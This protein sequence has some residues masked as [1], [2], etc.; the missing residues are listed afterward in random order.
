MPYRLCVLLCLALFALPGV[1]RAQPQEPPVDVR[2]SPLVLAVNKTAH[3]VVNIACLVRVSDKKG[4]EGEAEERLGT[5]VLVDT[6]KGLVL[7][8]AHVVQGATS[9]RVRL[10]SGRTLAAK[11]LGADP[12]FDIALLQLAVHDGLP[13]AAIFSRETPLLGETVVAI[14]NP[15]GF[16]HSVSM[17]LVSAMRRAVRSGERMLLTDLIQTDAAINP[18]NSGGPLVNMRGE[19][20]GITTAMNAYAQG[21]SFAIPAAKVLQVQ[22][23]ILQSRDMPVAWLGLA[24]ARGLDVG[25]ARKFGMTDT[26]GLLI[27]ALA[28]GGPAERSGLLVNDVITAI[29]ELPVADKRDYLDLMQNVAPGEML[30]V[31][32]WRKGYEGFTQVEAAPFDLPSIANLIWVRLGLK[33]GDTEAQARVSDIASKSPA[34][35]TGLQKGDTIVHLAGL[36]V[37]VK[38][39]F[40]VAFRNRMFTEQMAIEWLRD[41]KRMRKV[42]QL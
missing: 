2:V 33:L 41:G 22:Q 16:S 15:F 42:I 31:N 17:G 9:I 37:G 29:A 5:G 26:Q 4:Q 39:E 7:T 35:R 3:A 21:I 25:N 24:R 18:G 8:N 23:A 1:P 32:F 13:E 14:G 34:A 38:Q 27:T 20:I 19:I 36:R 11:Q 10:R 28:Q 40:Y 6:D 12:D 30:A